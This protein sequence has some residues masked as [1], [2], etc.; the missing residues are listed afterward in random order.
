MISIKGIAFVNGRKAR[1]CL[2]LTLGLLLAVS[3]FR[4][5][6]AAE[7]KPSVLR[8]G[9]TNSCFLGVNRNDA[10][11]SFKAFLATVGRQTRV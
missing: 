8:V 6:R 3:F 1:W 7:L 2:A 10:E 11:A 4:P 9:F 5:G